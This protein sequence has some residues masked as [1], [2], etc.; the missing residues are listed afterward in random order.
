MPS[1]SIS[2]FITANVAEEIRKTAIAKQ[3]NATIPFLLL[4]PLFPHFRYFLRKSVFWIFVIICHAIM[5]KSDTYLLVIGADLLKQ[6]M[7][8]F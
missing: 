4:L 2:F 7:I 1:L 3:S 5:G 6:P 8:P